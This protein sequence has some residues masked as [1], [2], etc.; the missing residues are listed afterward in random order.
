[1]SL[2]GSPQTVVSE[3][4]AVC[5]LATAVGPG[6]G[7]WAAGVLADVGVTLDGRLAERLDPVLAVLRRVRVDAAL[8]LHDGGAP[9]SGRIAAAEEHL[10]SWLLLDAARA[11]RVVDSLARPLWR[12]HVVAS[13]EGAAIVGRWLEQGPDPVT[14][15]LR[16]LDA[17]VVSDA[18]RSRT[19]T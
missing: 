3:G 6:W 9:T 18:L 7:P 17:P 8:L 14:R 1:M 15:H 4:L 19:S 10:R 2:L 12:A 5:A 13:V 11:R 16:L